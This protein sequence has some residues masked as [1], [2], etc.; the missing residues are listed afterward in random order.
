MLYLH[1]V[2]TYTDKT[3]SLFKDA[4]LYSVEDKPRYLPFQHNGDLAYFVHDGP[5]SRNNVCVCPWT[6]YQL[7]Q[8]CVKWRVCLENVKHG[9][10]VIYNYYLYFCHSFRQ[11]MQLLL[12]SQQSTYLRCSLK[13]IAYSICDEKTT[14][15]IYMFYEK[16]LYM[17]ETLFF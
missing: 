6:R 16:L 7:Y 8:R 12:M 13:N 3:P 9:C 2:R 5:G 10:H 1:A 14:T 17:S 4:V 15:F 11:K